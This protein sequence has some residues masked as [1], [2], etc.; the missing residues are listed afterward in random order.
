MAIS[1]RSAVSIAVGIAVSAAAGGLLMPPSGEAFV[2][3]GPGRSAANPLSSGTPYTLAASCSGVTDCVW[4]VTAGCTLAP[5]ADDFECE[6]LASPDF[7]VTCTTTGAK[8]ATLT[9]DD[10]HVDTT[11]IY[12]NT[13]P[14]AAAGADDSVA[15]DVAHNLDCDCTDDGLPNPPAATSCAWTEV[16]DG[17]CVFGNASLCETT[18]TC[19]TEGS[20]AVTCTCSDSVRTHPDALALTI[21]AGAC[22]NP[23]PYYAAACLDDMVDDAQTAVNA[24][25]FGAAYPSMTA[26]R[27]VM[28]TIPTPSASATVSTTAE[29]EACVNH[30]GSLAATCASGCTCTLDDDLTGTA[31]LVGPAG[32]SNSIVDCDGH[33]IEDVTLSSVSHAVERIEFRNCVIQERF[34]SLQFASAEYADDVIVRNTVI[35]TT[36]QGSVTISATHQ[37]RWLFVSVIVYHRTGALEFGVGEDVTIVNSNFPARYPMDGAGAWWLRTGDCDR[38]AAIDVHGECGPQR[39]FRAGSD[40]HTV[41][42]KVFW[43]SPTARATARKMRLVNPEDAF[44][45]SEFA[46]NGAEEVDSDYSV[47]MYFDAYGG[48]ADQASVDFGGCAIGSDHCARLSVTY[49]VDLYSSTGYAGGATTHVDQSEAIA[50]EAAEE[51]TGGVTAACSGLTERWELDTGDLNTYNLWTDY[52]VNTPYLDLPALPA[53]VDDDFGTL[54]TQD[55]APSVNAGSDDDATED[56]AYTLAATVTDDGLPRDQLWCSWTTSD[57][58]TF[59][60]GADLF[61]VDSAGDEDFDVTCGSVDASATL[62]LCCDDDGNAAAS[63]AAVCNDVVLNVESGATPLALDNFDQTVLG[64]WCVPAKLV[65]SYEGPLIQIRDIDDDATLDV[66][67][68]GSTVSTCDNGGTALDTTAIGTFCDDGGTQDCAVS[69][70]YDQGPGDDD[71]S[72]ATEANMPLL[73]DNG[74]VIVCGSQNDPCMFFQGNLWSFNG[75]QGSWLAR[76]DALGLTGNPG[77]AFYFLSKT[78]AESDDRFMFDLGGGDGASIGMMSSQTNGGR[79]SMSTR[80]ASIDFDN[81]DEGAPPDYAGYVFN[82]PS[83]SAQVQTNTLYK[84]THAA[85]SGALTCDSGCASTATV[86]L[87]NDLTRWGTSTRGASDFNFPWEGWASCFVV[88]AAGATAGGDPE[89]RAD[90]FTF[91]NARD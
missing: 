83:G 85:N 2:D 47:Y 15:A 84:G 91:T 86:N 43:S 90:W 80:S 76:S 6:S 60:S 57:D 52:D 46:A 1:R 48:H 37:R 23:V 7:A 10:D 13:A 39:C 62:T 21:T 8:T 40:F 64:A 78:D 53:V 11:T 34:S 58:C 51:N 41:E 27:P 56:V 71:L 38:V 69:I 89:D 65:T 3:A 35:G 42:G 20:T 73:Q 49:D 36:D 18:I 28:P 88:T 19:D 31:Q 63:D 29:L 50:A 26:L 68:V 44:I 25:G 5:G 81:N 67:C 72:Q 59:E 61:V 74:S 12:S 22:A 82:W 55:A 32:V 9:C 66:G 17:T 14:V 77:V 24:A 70:V 79:W 45:W 87:T 4:T 30:T 75:G 16:G 33:S 54:D